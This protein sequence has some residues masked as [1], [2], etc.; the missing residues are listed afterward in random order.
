[1]E[2]TKAAVSVADQLG[3]PRRQCP[4]TRTWFQ[5]RVPW[6]QFVN[7]A[8][9]KAFHRSK[10]QE[11]ERRLQEVIADNT[12]WREAVAAAKAE[13]AKRVEAKAN[14]HV[15]PTPYPAPYRQPGGRP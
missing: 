14:V 6:Q 1:M 15:A 10:R 3:T 8:A 2:N 5:P 4:Q 12:Q 9:R 7:P 13:A 11:L